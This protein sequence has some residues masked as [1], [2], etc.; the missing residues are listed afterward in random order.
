[1]QYISDFIGKELI[2]ETFEL[3]SDRKV[4]EEFTGA[5]INYSNDRPAGKNFWIQPH[6][7]LYQTG[8]QQQDVSCFELNDNKAF[9]KTGG[10]LGFDIFAASFYL[11]SRYEEY[12][13]HR[14]DEYGRYDHVQSIAYQNDFL[15]LPI[16]NIWLQDFKLKIR[17]FFPEINFHHTSFRFMPT[18]DIDMAWTYKHKG[19]WR[20]AGGMIKSLAKGQFAELAGR[21]NI[22]TGREK[23]PYD[24]FGWMHELHEKYSLRPHYF[25]LL[26]GKTG[27]YDKNI[28]RHKKEMRDLIADHMIR[29]PIGIHPSW[30]SGDQPQLVRDEI[31]FLST[32][33]GNKVRSSRQHFIRMKIPDTYRLLID[34]G[35]QFDFSMGYGGINGFRASVASPFNWYDLEKEEKTALVLFPFC[36]MDATS[37]YELKHTATQAFKEMRHYE[38]VVKSVNGLLIMIWHNSFLG[39]DLLHTGWREMYNRFVNGLQKE[40]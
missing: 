33:M 9:F 1:L 15:H 23:D 2:D 16:V 34:N 3:T 7:L 4:F 25:F 40:V 13:P 11:L 21:I 29:Y 37:F 5:K 36:Y 39:T 22:L 24:S 6:N 38:T 28:G 12:L 14:L 19:W 20:T 35:I 32:V 8:I 30:A 17:D 31:D 26:A 10:D 18:Y 27:R